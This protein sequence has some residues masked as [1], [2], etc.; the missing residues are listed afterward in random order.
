MQ[1]MRLMINP[2]SMSREKQQTEVFYLVSPEK[3]KILDLISS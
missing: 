3:T 1:V 2:E